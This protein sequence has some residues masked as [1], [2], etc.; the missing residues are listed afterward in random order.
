[1]YLFFS[2]DANIGHC[3]DNWE[4]EWMRQ[5]E[6]KEGFKEWLHLNNK[7]GN[8]CVGYMISMFK[9]QVQQKLS[10]VIPL[11]YV[12]TDKETCHI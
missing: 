10:F 1:M 4:R 3:S 7:K 11:K 8:D 12:S 9:K 5:R 2:V 6:G